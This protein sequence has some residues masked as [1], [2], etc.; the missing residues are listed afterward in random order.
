MGIPGKALGAFRGLS[1]VFPEIL[2][3][4]PSRSGGM[5]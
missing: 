4:S 3:E 5:A 2:P 1:G